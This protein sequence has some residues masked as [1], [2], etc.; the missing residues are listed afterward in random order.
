MMLCTKRLS[1]RPWTESDAE[2]LYKYAK[3]PQVGPVAGWPPH[4]DVENSRQIIREVLSAEETYA[5]VLRETDEPVGSV[6]IMLPPRATHTFMGENDAEI[7][8]WIGVPYWGQGLIPEAVNELIRRGFEDL[9]LSALWCGYY[10]GNEQSRRVQEKCGFVYHHT[11]Y[12]VPCPMIDE[13]RT[14]HFTVLTKQEWQES[15]DD[16][17]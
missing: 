17:R 8:Y 12:G 15:K 5:V 13:R 3:D 9:G 6:G 1:L 2:A 14:E 11:E 7:G 10:D 16:K 4:T